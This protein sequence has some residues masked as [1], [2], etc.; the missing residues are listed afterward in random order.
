ML[1]GCSSAAGT[2]RL[3]IEGTMNGAK[4]RQILDKNPLQRANDLRLGGKI[5]ILTGQ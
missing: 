2:G 3:R 4:Y 5:C 1:W